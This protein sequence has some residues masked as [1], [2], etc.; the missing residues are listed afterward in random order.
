[1]AE[2]TLHDKIDPKGAQ[3]GAASVTQA[4]NTMRKAAAQ[5][6]RDM[7]RTVSAMDKVA[8]AGKRMTA[9]GKTMSVALTAPIAMLGKSILSTAVD[10]E[11]SMLRVEAVTQAT[12]DTVTQLTDKAKELG[13]S[14]KFSA[15]EAAQGMAFLGQAARRQAL[16]P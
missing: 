9:V 16:S 14:T 11:S 5:A 4:L 7:D 10:F 8:A 3:A 15:T 12:G 6:G 1:M 13:I 2:S